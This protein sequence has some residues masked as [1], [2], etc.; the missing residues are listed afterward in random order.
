[1]L[2]TLFV[3]VNAVIATQLSVS[4]TGAT[5][6]IGAP[7]IFGACSG[8]LSRMLSKTIGKR[9]IYLVASVLMLVATMW[10][11]HVYSNYAAFMA[12][13]VF[14]G[15]GWGAVEG[16]MAESISDVFQVRPAQPS[17]T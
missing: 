3:T 1:M 10:N 7:L 16:L 11:M 17:T 15:I 2:K 8:V 9:G 6:L 14:Q 13:R 4:Y 12:S 5:A